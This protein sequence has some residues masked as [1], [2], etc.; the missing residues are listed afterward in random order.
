MCTRVASL[1]HRQ[2]RTCT[3]ASVRILQDAVVQ[4]SELV[5]PAILAFLPIWMSR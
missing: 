1:W 2:A 3:R 4:I 5:A